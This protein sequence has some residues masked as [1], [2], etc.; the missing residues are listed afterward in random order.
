MGQSG[1]LRAEAV[2]DWL[3]AAVKRLTDNANT[4]GQIA[5]NS[6]ATQRFHGSG[7][8]KYRRVIHPELSKTGTCGLCAVAATNVFSTAD[9]L[10]MHNN[11]KCT[12][13]PITANN[14]PGLKLNR[15]DLDAIYRKAGSTSA[16]DLK[17]ARVIMESHSEIGPILT[18]S[19]WRREYDDGTPAPEWHIPDLKMTRTALQRMYASYGVPTALSESAGYGRGRRFPF[20]GRKYSFRPSVHLRQAMSYQR[21]WLQYLRSTLGLA[22]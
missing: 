4:D 13:A 17:S 14:D 6:A 19:Q 5:M 7:V 9:L 18:Q 11:C 1:R 2:D 12:V 10:P 22:A 8:R 15:E 20:E 16:A 3:D 21:A